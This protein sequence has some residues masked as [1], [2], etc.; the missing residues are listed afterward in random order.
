MVVGTWSAVPKLWGWVPCV[1]ATNQHKKTY[2][3]RKEKVISNPCLGQWNPHAWS[4]HARGEGSAAYLFAKSLQPY[5]FTAFQWKI[6]CQKSPTN[7]A[8]WWL[9]Y[10]M[11]TR[12]R[13]SILGLRK[14]WDRATF[15]WSAIRRI[16]WWNRTQDR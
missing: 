13:T 14:L 10:I 1:T 15:T 9:A 4:W 7:K 11:P 6:N 8:M 3:L 2:Y 16:E 5:R 12:A